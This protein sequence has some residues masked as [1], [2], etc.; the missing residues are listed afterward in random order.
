MKSHFILYLI[1]FLNL[2]FKVDPKKSQEM[3][4][5]FFFPYSS[6]V[7]FSPPYC[8]T[9]EYYCIQLIDKLVATITCTNTA[10]LNNTQCQT[11][12]YFL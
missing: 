11:S 2:P 9:I 10:R 3:K 8:T 5:M 7:S 4:K 6:T 12:I 1:F